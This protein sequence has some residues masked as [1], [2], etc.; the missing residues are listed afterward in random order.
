MSNYSELLKHPKWQKKRLE[1]LERDKFECRAC[2]RKDKTLHV[3]HLYYDY[4]LK[5]WEYPNYDLI[6]LC[7]YCHDILHLLQKNKIDIYSAH[8]VTECITKQECINIMNWR[9]RKEKENG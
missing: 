9:N 2:E 5:P 7:E 6:T 3:H 1:I 8:I 4:D